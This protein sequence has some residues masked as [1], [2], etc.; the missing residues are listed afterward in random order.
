MICSCAGVHESIA[1]DRTN[2]MCT[3][4]DLCVLFEQFVVFDMSVIEKYIR[5]ESAQV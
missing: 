1:I 2:E 5:F 3:P 4:N